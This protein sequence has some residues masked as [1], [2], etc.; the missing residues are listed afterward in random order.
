MDVDT[1]AKVISGEPS[2]ETTNNEGEGKKH[3]E[4]ASESKV[5]A[6]LQGNGE[7]EENGPQRRHFPTAESSTEEIQKSSIKL[8]EKPADHG[9]IIAGEGE[10][11]NER[12]SK[13]VFTGKTEESEESPKK[14]IRKMVPDAANKKDRVLDTETE[15]EERPTKLSRKMVPDATNKQDH[16]LSDAVVDDNAEKERKHFQQPTDAVKELLTDGAAAE[17]DNKEDQAKTDNDRPA[18]LTSVDLN[19]PRTVQPPTKPGTV[20]EDRAAGVS[21]TELNDA[22][23]GHADCSAQTTNAKNNAMAGTAMA[24]SLTWTES[25]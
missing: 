10:P 1:A 21:S 11:E 19:R 6:V 13:R 24:D 12:P 7:V 8:V 20:T 17:E 2:T 9:D 16:I 23:N 22:A 18:G 14:K 4:E 3:F 25:N 5:G 15:E